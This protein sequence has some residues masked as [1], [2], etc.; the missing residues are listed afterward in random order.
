MKLINKEIRIETT[1]ICN[2]HCVMCPR[3]KL[4][5]EKGTMDMGL[6]KRIVDEVLDYGVQNV[7]LGGFGESLLDPFFVERVRYVKSLGL[8]CNFICNGS[9]MDETKAR[10]LIDAGL[11]EVRFSVYGAAGR[12]YSKVHRG[13]DFEKT[14]GNILK[15]LDLKNSLGKERPK[16]LVFYLMLEENAA[17]WEDFKK[18]W[19]DKADAIEI[20][21]PHNF[22]DGRLYRSV[23][24][25]PRRSCN[26]PQVGPVQIQWDGTVI[27]CCWD[28]DGKMILGDMKTHTLAEILR[29]EKYQ[30][31]RDAHNANEFSA[32]PFC[33]QCDQ[34]IDHPDALVFSNRHDLPPEIAV[35]LTNSNLYSLT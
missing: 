23:N 33:S 25:G 26:R 28:Y 13:L 7:F 4:T 10:E 3:E 34:L 1:N 16:V 24:G 32:Y 21:K 20:W 6:F 27:P 9:L 12:T 14:A 17:E 35:N 11:D 31:I 18:E 22:G 19:I 5:R 2:A 15:L 29:S 8:F 30:A